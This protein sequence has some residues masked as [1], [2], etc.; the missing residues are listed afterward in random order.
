MF[1]INLTTEVIMKVSVKKVLS[2]LLAASALLSLCAC[3]S[4][5]G[6]GGK[7][8]AETPAPEFVYKSDFK[9]LASSNTSDIYPSLY[10]KDGFYYFTSEKVGTEIPEGAVVEWEGQYDIY[11]QRLKFM[12]FDGEIKTLSDYSQLEPEEKLEGHDYWSYSSGMF[13]HNDTLY[14]VDEYSENWSDAPEGVEMYSDEWYNYYQY[15]SFYYLRTFDMNG[16][17]L[18]RVKLETPNDSMYSGGF[19]I[20]G[21]AI[22]GQGRLI[23]SSDT[24]LLVFGT[25]GRMLGSVNT[26]NAWVEGLVMLNDGTV[27]AKMYKQSYELVPVNVDSKSFGAPIKVEGYPYTIVPGGGDYD[28]YYIN[29][30]NCMGLDIETGKSE[31]L[32]NWLNC[33]VNNDNLSSF[34][35]TDDGEIKAVLT[36]WDNKYQVSESTLVT[37]KKVPYD[38]SAEKQTLT[39]AT[40]YLEWNMKNSLIKFNRTNPDFRIE[41]KDYSEYNTEEDYSAGLT[42]LKAEMLAGNM[43]DIIDLNG[44]PMEQLAAKGLLEDLY[45]FIDNDPEIKREDF[46]PNILSALEVNGKLCTTC[47]SFS[48]NTLC[49]AASIVGSKPGWTLADLKSALSMM[50]E[51]CDILNYYTTKSDILYNL[52]NQSM[53]EFVDWAT[54]KCYFDS[55]KFVDILEFANQFPKEFDWDN[56]MYVEGDDDFTRISEGRQ[57]LMQGYISS[58]D[59]LEY[60]NHAFGGDM[61]F[62]GYPTT[63]GNGAVMSL[64]T[65]YAISSTCKVKEQAW[66]FI[67]TL[68]TP[69]YLSGYDIYYY[70]CSISAFNAKLEEA[71]TPMYETDINGNYILDENGEKIEMSR[72]GYGTSDGTVFQYYAMSQEM[73]DKLLEL[74]EGTTVVASNNDDIMEIVNAEVEAY[75]SGQKTAQDVAK[76]VQSKVNIYVSEHM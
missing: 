3:G 44:M 74:I 15:S 61:T 71:M 21:S 73:A 43:P 26:D 34:T 50:P 2:I 54:G 13:V 33:D 52:V 47:S 55:Q 56:Y 69:D 30:L 27:L 5:S 46:F 19:Y 29:G 24:S 72:G 6:D 1:S 68:M 66:Q 35:V 22:D 63:E 49:G 31:K 25:D 42:K 70:P 60:Y 4:K 67:R 51:G 16:K 40:Q 59:E 23:V 9:L 20:Y 18:S 64:Q 58:F 76:L 65:G 45:P 41:V 37:V 17:E 38:P 14:S 10:T 39:L 7:G 57:L 53:G 12:S 36:E 28:L 32:F 11:E 75:F 48:I 8:P 62:I